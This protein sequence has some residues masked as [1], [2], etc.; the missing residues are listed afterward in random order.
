LAGLTFRELAQYRKDGMLTEEEFAAVKARI[1]SA[2]V[3]K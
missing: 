1:F 2:A 3:N